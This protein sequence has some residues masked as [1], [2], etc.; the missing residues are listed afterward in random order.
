M[1]NLLVVV[2]QLGDLECGLDRVLIVDLPMEDVRFLTMVD[3]IPIE[4]I[5]QVQD[6]GPMI[7]K[8]Q[9]HVYHVPI[10]VFQVLLRKQV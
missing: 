6:L 1:H 2:I 3:C 10:Q 5:V 9:E 8:M 4:D 7:L